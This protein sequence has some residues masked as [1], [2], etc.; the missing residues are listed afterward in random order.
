MQEIASDL[1]DGDE[2]V[3]KF[4]EDLQNYISTLSPIEKIEKI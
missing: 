1:V 3:R 4:I 2:S